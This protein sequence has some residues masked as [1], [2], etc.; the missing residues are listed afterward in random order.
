MN[1]S[2]SGRVARVQRQVRRP[3]C[4]TASIATTSSAPRSRHNPTTVSGPA[5]APPAAA[6]AAPPAPPAPRTDSALPAHHRHRIRSPR[7][8]R[9]EQLRHRRPPAPAP[10]CRSTPPAPGARSAGSSTATWCSRA[11]GSAATAAS[12]RTSRAA[13]S[14]A[15]AASNRSA[16]AVTVPAQPARAALGTGHLGH[17]DIQVEPGLREPGGYRGGGDPGQARC[18]GRRSAGV[19]HGR[20]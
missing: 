15:V 18:P 3:A 1:A 6:P 10:R 20:A 11:C 7:R 16:A 5:P 13:I 12:T 19:L 8:L 2:R 14:A 9:R 4:H 17:R